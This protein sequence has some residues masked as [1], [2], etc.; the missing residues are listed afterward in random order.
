MA[1]QYIVYT[2]AINVSTCFRKISGPNLRFGNYLI[3]VGAYIRGGL[4]FGR[5]FVLVS[6]GGLYAG[7]SYIRGA[8]VRDFT[9]FYL[10]DNFSMDCT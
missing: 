3:L 2:M 6:R 9:V 7:G 10:Q 1:S 5:E 8:Y 4:I